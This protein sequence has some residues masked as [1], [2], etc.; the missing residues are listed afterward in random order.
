MVDI[1]PG[2][3]PKKAMQ[4]SRNTDD[5]LHSQQGRD[6]SPFWL[7]RSFKPLRALETARGS[8]VPIMLVGL[9]VLVALTPAL[10]SGPAQGATATQ[11]TVTP[12]TP[13]STATVEVRTT[14][15]SGDSTAG[16]NLNAISIDLDRAS[17][18]EVQ[19][20]EVQVIVGPSGDGS[21]EADRARAVNLSTDANSRRLTARLNDSLAIAAGDRVQV[22]IS[23]VQTPDQEG[24]YGARLT[25]RTEAGSSEGPITSSYRIQSAHVSLPDQQAE[26]P[27]QSQANETV[28]RTIRVSALMPNGGYIAVFTGRNGD[29]DDLV[30]VTRVQSSSSNRTYRV[31]LNISENQELI[32]VPYFESGE[33][34]F[35]D[36]QQEGFS[37][38]ADEPYVRSNEVISDQGSIVLRRPTAQ[39]RSGG[40]YRVGAQLLFTQGEPST[41]YELRAVDD[42]RAGDEIIA[43]QTNQTGVAVLDSTNLSTNKYAIVQ[44]TG[45]D[46]VNLDGDSIGSAADDGFTVIDPANSTASGEGK[47]TTTAVA[48]SSGGGLN[49]MVLFLFVIFAFAFGGGVAMIYR[50]RQSY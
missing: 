7:G 13:S 32:A 1:D 17:F 18:D 19:P 11:V 3:H 16:E 48:P 12:A 35:G 29:P 27:A 45:S 38:L 39:I 43:F 28:T 49:S 24:S 20:S 40:Q 14:I 47:N 9:L 10:M 46:V 6:R 8:S 21:G 22:R 41:E 33:R 5:Y 25:L 2:T 37:Q 23:N 34:A 26:G 50:R 44:V 15:Q 4:S 36:D 42:G 31:R 30:G